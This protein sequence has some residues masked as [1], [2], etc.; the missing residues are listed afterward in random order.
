MVFHTKIT[1]FDEIFS[2]YYRIKKVYNGFHN[3]KVFLQISTQMWC[4]TP[5]AVCF[6]KKILP[7]FNG[8][9]FQKVREN[10]I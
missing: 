1:F 9:L 3:H 6:I 8:N 10:L 5:A 4:H 2:G 7:W